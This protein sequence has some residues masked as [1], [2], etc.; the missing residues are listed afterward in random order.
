M[1]RE[2]NDKEIIDFFK[3]GCLSYCAIYGTLFALSFLLASIIK[4]K[5]KNS[6]RIEQFYSNEDDDEYVYICTGKKSYAYHSNRDCIGLQQCGSQIIKVTI[7][8][9][10]DEDRT[11]CNFCY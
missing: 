3:K 9:A 5:D 1:N 11:P 7:D 10:I 4:C 8:E 6:S 2:R